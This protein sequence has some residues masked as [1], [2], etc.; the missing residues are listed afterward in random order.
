[1]KYSHDLIVI[2]G[3]AAGLVAAGGC[4]MF[5]LKTA[6]IEGEKMGGECLNNGCVPSKALIASARRAAE[7]RKEKRAGVQ[8][9]PPVVDW[10]GVHAHILAPLRKSPPMTARNA[11][12]IWAARYCAIGPELSGPTL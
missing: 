6:L 12:R 3:G 9:A 4:A 10:G 1:M 8:L 7:A 2:G 5:G 11:L